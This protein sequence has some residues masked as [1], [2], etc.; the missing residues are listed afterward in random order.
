MC[1]ICETR[2]LCDR[3]ERQIKNLDA[4]GAISPT[5][6]REILNDA[7]NDLRRYGLAGGVSEMILAGQAVVDIADLDLTGFADLAR[8]GPLH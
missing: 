5:A 4:G 8:K 6:I 2:K 7:L 1:H 3:L